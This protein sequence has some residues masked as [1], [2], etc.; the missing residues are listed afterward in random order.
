MWNTP[1]HLIQRRHILLSGWEKSE[2]L[3][4]IDSTV[5]QKQLLKE[6]QKFHQWVQNKDIND[7]AKATLAEKKEYAQSL[8]DK[9]TMIIWSTVL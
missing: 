8:F 5:L 3:T 1:G 9:K 6:Y 7:I 4:K 2:D